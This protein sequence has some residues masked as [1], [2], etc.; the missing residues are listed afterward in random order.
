MVTRQREEQQDWRK[1]IGELFWQRA[2]WKIKGSDLTAGKG[3]EVVPYSLTKDQELSRRPAS[4][5]AP[6]YVLL[7]ERVFKAEICTLARANLLALFN[8]PTTTTIIIITIR[9]PFSLLYNC[10]VPS[11]THQ[12]SYIISKH[13]PSKKK[14]GRF[15][16]CN[17]IWCPYEKVSGDSL[18]PVAQSHATNEIQCSL[19][20]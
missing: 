11:K 10:P 18:Y 12:A 5:L 9:T 7:I 4:V 14:N 2:G 13:L 20:P 1:L 6:L 8:T 3:F 15:C 19:T 16:N 17:T